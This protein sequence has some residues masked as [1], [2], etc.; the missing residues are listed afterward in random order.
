[1]LLQVHCLDRTMLTLGVERK[2]GMALAGKDVLCLG[3]FE[4]THD[5]GTALRPGKRQQ[6]GPGLK[7]SK[8]RN[9]LGRQRHR[10]KC[11]DQV[12]KNSMKQQLLEVDQWMIG[13][14]DQRSSNCLLWKELEVVIY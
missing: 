4:V 2:L 11:A 6:N 13:S 9:P 14:E 1:M 10:Y 12:V 7:A 3:V 8:A 5:H